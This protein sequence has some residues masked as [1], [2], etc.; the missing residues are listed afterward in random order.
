MVLPNSP[1][2]GQECP[3][4]IPAC[5]RKLHDLRHRT[6]GLRPTDG[7]EACPTCLGIVDTSLFSLSDLD[8]NGSPPSGLKSILKT[9]PILV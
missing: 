2:D 5:V 6:V 4:Y 8:D 1:E 3:S 9:S 7:L